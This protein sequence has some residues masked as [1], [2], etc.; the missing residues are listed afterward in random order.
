MALGFFSLFLR[1]GHT[2]HRLAKE[3]RAESQASRTALPPTAVPP[4][5]TWSESLTQKTENGLALHVRV[6]LA[7]NGQNPALYTSHKLQMVLILPSP[8]LEL[9][10]PAPGY[11]G[12]GFTSSD[13]P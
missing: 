7:S 6:Q 10:L 8:R 12:H 9:S 11:L 13:I 4:V 2:Q 3:R 5:S 1:S